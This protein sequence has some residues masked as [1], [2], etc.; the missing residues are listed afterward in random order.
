MFDKEPVEMFENESDVCMFWGAARTYDTSGCTVLK[1][2]KFLKEKIGGDQ[3]R[4]SFCRHPGE[5]NKMKE[6]TAEGS[7]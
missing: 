5:T 1:T 7:S 4:E 3:T 6:T 2:L